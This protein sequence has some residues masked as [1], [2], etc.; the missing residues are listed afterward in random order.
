MDLFKFA[1]GPYEFFAAILGGVPLVLAIFLL[2]NP[3]TGVQDFAGLMQT[4][5]SLQVLIALAFVSY[6][7]G[8]LAQG[9]TW[10]FF[11]ALCNMFDRDLHYFST[12]VL[13]AR[14]EWLQGLAKDVDPKTLDFE[15]R[16]V[17]LLHNKVGIPN[18][19]NHL[20]S[21][22]CSYLK[23]NNR[24]S[25][26]TADLYQAT[27]IM[28]RNLSFGLLIL[29]GVFLVNVFRVGAVS[30]EQVALFFGALVLAYI[31][32]VRSASFKRWHSR[33]VL[34]GFYFAAC[35]ERSP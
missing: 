7:L 26:V 28:Y 23:E 24:P 6:L 15:S 17:L 35:N 16:L 29:S 1:L 31:A 3:A 22:V 18:K 25:L 8:G 5:F 2:Y 33:E 11:L 4:S 10:K 21:R 34:L 27:H 14:G 12:E 30:F 13:L 32:F 19:M 9:V 20:Y